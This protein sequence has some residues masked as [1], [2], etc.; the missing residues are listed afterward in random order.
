MLQKKAEAQVAKASNLPDNDILEKAKLTSRKPVFPNKFV[1][2]LVALVL[3]IL[4][5]FIGLG[6][7]SFADNTISDEKMVEKMTQLPTLGKIYHRK[8]NATQNSVMIE[9]PRS[10][11][12]ES[13]RT[14][15]MNAQFQLHKGII[16]QENS[17]NVILVTSSNS[18]EGKSF[19]S[20]N[21]AVSLSLLGKKTVLLDFDLR[22]PND[23]PF[24]KGENELGVSSLLT[25]K[26]TLKDI[27]VNTGISNFDFIPA[28]SIPE[29]PA[30][31]IGSEEAKILIE[32]MESKYDYV[33]IDTP[34]VGLVT[35][36]YL[37]AEY[38]DLKILVV[39][40][41]VTLKDHIA[42]IFKEI[43]EKKIDNVC[44]ILNDVD[45]KNTYYGVKN[46]YY[47]VKG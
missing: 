39:R 12:A 41:K 20:L 14:V 16:S 7:K 19:V 25:G 33:I 42:P 40:E 45:I 35:D 34:P 18:G 27:H 26:A 24:F 4:L 8:N 9:A 31:L 10:A 38:A 15:R 47:D 17:R 11:I 36:A 22:K 32:A 29:N 13:I 23:T 3:G 44:W 37:I 6:V 30:E 46:D 1:N 5:P 21:L 28:G 43:E 2:Y